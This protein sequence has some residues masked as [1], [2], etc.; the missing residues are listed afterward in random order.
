MAAPSVVAVPAH[1]PDMVRLGLRFPLLPYTSCVQLHLPACCAVRCGCAGGESQGLLVLGVVGAS[2]LSLA[3]A[4]PF[5]LE[6]IVVVD[7]LSS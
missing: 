5:E 2:L 1:A 4:A 7:M 6:Y 3:P